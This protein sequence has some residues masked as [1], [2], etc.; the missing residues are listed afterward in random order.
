VLPFEEEPQHDA[1]S[2]EIQGRLFFATNRP[3][4][5]GGLDIDVPGIGLR[6]LWVSTRS[7]PSAPWST[8]QNLGSVVNTVFNDMLAA[9]SSDG[10]TLVL[11]SDR[12]EGWGGLDLYIA[13]RSRP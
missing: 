9:L 8:P 6:D 4:G 7:S 13:T 11:T 3:G 2:L 1:T 12:P 5:S 10:T